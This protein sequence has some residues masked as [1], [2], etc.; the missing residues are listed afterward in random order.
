MEMVCETVTEYIWLRVGS[1]AGCCEHGNEHSSSSN[2]YWGG[3]G[4]P[5]SATDTISIPTLT[6]Q[7]CSAV[8]FGTFLPVACI[9]NCNSDA[10]CPETYRVFPHYLS[11]NGGIIPQNIM[12]ASLQLLSNSLLAK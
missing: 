7:T 10:I 11:A 6:D 12:T 8:T 1:S 5:D 4:G 3:G 2:L 9:S